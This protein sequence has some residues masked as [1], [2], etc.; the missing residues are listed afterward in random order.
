[1]MKIALS[2][3]CVMTT[4][5]AEIIATSTPTIRTAEPVHPIVKP[6]V[7]PTR[8]INRPIL[9]RED[10]NYY[11]NTVSSCAEYIR[12]IEQKDGEIDRLKK[13]IASLTGK[14]HAKLQKNLKTEYE[15]ELQKFDERKSSIKTK[16]S[17]DVFDK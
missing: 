16:N 13:E 4:M 11:S 1:M 3:M 17:I 8:P 9:V 6:S 5:F 2:F 7:R 12:I 15:Q 14:E 10:Y